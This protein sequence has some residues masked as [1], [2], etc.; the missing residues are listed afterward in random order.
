ME[1]FKKIRKIDFDTEYHNGNY[2]E[3]VKELAEYLRL[4]NECFDQQQENF[5]IIVHYVYK[6]K[7]LFDNH[8]KI[9]FGAVYSKNS[10][11]Y[12]FDS[13]MLSFGFDKTQVSRI[14]Q[15]HSKFLDVVDEQPFL[16]PIFAEFSKSKLFEL[17]PVDN[18][19][20]TIDIR[21]SLLRPN[22]SVKQ[23]REYVK[24]Y[25][26]LEI[27]NKKLSEEPKE[28]EEAEKPIEEY[29]PLAYNP[30]QH[31][32]FSYFEK[33]SKAQLLNIVWELQKEYECLKK[34]V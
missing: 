25:K 18:H 4:L 8:K 13:I 16:K 15:V 2:S 32:D 9:C 33:Q 24:N 1:N 20:L 7:E 22:M 3:G 29:I 28:Q 10:C 21:K 17:I 11:Y 26:S 30:K 23:I 19:Q 5:A 31:Y 34:K 27:Q 12:N 14:L 6:V